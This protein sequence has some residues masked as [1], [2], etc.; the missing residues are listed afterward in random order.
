MA[1]RVHSLSLASYFPRPVPPLCG[2]AHRD[3]AALLE[4]KGD[5]PTV[6]TVPE[7]EGELGAGDLL[8]DLVKG[9]GARV[10]QTVE[11]V[12]E[13][14]V[15]GRAIGFDDVPER[16]RLRRRGLRIE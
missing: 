2:I 3:I 11:H 16:R 4:P 8:D 15:L 12:R 10:S 1:L 9:R 6:P 7:P 5:L 14:G 13:L